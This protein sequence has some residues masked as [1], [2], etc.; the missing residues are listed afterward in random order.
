LDGG[1]YAFIRCARDR[2]RRS[3]LPTKCCRWVARSRFGGLPDA[4]G[5]R[6]DRERRKGTTRPRSSGA[7]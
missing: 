2:R 6:Q 3:L 5:Q 1:V 4:R 7:T